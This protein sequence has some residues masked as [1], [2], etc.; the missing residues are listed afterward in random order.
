M[1]DVPRAAD[2]SG[3]VAYIRVIPEGFE[4]PQFISHDIDVIY[5]AFDDAGNSAECIVQIRIPGFI[6]N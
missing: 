6:P 2:N 1:F 5:T 3:S 4:P